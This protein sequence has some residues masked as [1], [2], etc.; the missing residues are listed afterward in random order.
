M[1][2]HP[3]AWSGGIRVTDLYSHEY[4]GKVSL[5]TDNPQRALANVDI[6]LLCL[7][8]YAIESTLRSLKHYLKKEQV[9]GS[10]VS[11]TGF[12]YGA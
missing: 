12:F 8:G 6:I 4:F 5:V 1:A 9:M 2:K 7:P 3:L 11:S 10:I